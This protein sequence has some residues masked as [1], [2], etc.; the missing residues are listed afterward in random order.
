MS[1]EKIVALSR[2][3]IIGIV[4]LFFSLLFF[5]ITLAE[6]FVGSLYGNEIGGLKEGL[7][8]IE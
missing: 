5:E 6:I 8:R 3:F 4:F 2:I 1:G 7:R